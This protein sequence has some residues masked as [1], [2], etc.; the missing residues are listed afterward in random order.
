MLTA[1][2][3]WGRL[4][5]GDGAADLMRALPDILQTR[6]WFGGKARRVAGIRIVDS[7]AVP[8]D[9]SSILLLLGVEYRDA[10]TEIYS[11][12]VTAVFGED[13]ERV[14]RG[15][16]PAAILPFVLKKNGTTDTGILYDALWNRVFTTELLAALRNEARF[17]GA[18][19]AVRASVTAAFKDLVPIGIRLD[20]RV[21]GAEQSNTSVAYDGQV[22]LKLYRRLE[23]G[24]NPDL[25]IGRVLTRMQFP[26]VP[27]L[28]GAL[29]YQRPSREVSTLG[30]LQRYV[31]NAGDAWTWSLEAVKEFFTRVGRILDNHATGDTS[32]LLQ[33]TG[34]P[35]PAR[36][37]HLM[38]GYLESAERLGQRTAQLHLALSRVQ[39]DPAFAPERLTPEYRQGRYEA[40]LR[41]MASALA[42]LKDRMHSLP[43]GA[44]EQATHL[45]GLRPALEDIFGAFRNVNTP[46]SLIRCHGDYHLGQVLFT[47]ADFVITD[48]EGEPARPLAERRMKRPPLV[49]IAGMVRS[50][51]YVPFAFLKGAGLPPSPWCQ[52]WSDWACVGFLKG[53]LSAAAG[54][55]LWPRT[56]EGVGLLLDAYV[57]EKAFYELQYE[58]NNRPDW[59]DIPLHGLSAMLK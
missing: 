9:S 20:P 22:I 34:E 47:G 57:A 13:A 45:C 12:P 36:V 16:P 42:L 43:T 23:E 55:E 4:L 30:V 54:S 1:K 29:E 41:S 39:D 46:V 53:Y 15:I 52:F 18:V 38:G 21:M 48:F 51:Q 5:E 6:R 24:I 17:Q 3:D 10:E 2:H 59:V 26:F 27:A 56:N 33:L 49:D 50:F 40:A 28:A 14:Q 25:E 37:C 8:S 11:L 32:S 31:E 58:L 19:G 35:Y 7:I 44:Q